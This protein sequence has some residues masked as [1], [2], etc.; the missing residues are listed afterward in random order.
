MTYYYSHLDLINIIND[1]KS[2]GESITSISDNI[3]CSYST[4]HRALNNRSTLSTKSCELLIK[5]YNVNSDYLYGG[6]GPMYKEDTK[7]AIEEPK[8]PDYRITKAELQE[9]IACLESIQENGFAIQTIVS[10]NA[11]Q[12]TQGFVIGKETDQLDDTVISM[13]KTLSNVRNRNNGD[14]KT[15]GD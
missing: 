3:G 9:L 12:I 7:T 8:D 10:G 15:L 4:L 6:F 14:N 1:L 5:N 2:K 13:S 11:S